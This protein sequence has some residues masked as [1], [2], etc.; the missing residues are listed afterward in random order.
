MSP[1]H[2]EARATSAEAGVTLVEM[3]IV[4]A[5]VGL[6][7]SISYPSVSAGLDS[8]RLRAASNEVVSFLNVALERAVRHQE[9]VEI[10]I[11]PLE[12][13]LSARTANGAFTRSADLADP[14]KILSVQ[15]VPPGVDARVMRR[16]LIYPGGSVPKIGV[17]IG[18][19]SG[20]KKMV[21]VDPV[22]GMPLVVN[23]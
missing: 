19:A 2:A 3:L 15:P 10:R 6:I 14:V 11:A 23:E 8:M 17:E 1:R 18:T 12:N 21:S 20:R 4:V 22:T 7:A 9:V 5:L 16:F 13:A